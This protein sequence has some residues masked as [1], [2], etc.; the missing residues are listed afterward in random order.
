MDIMMPDLNGVDTLKKLKEIEGFNTPVIALTVD[1]MDGSR[2]KYL[3]AGF[4]EYVS[5]PIIKEI[6]EKALNKYVDV[7]DINIVKK[8]EDID[9]L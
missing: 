1:S 6:L 3:A 4:D 8:D 2:E 5:K 7:E 9:V